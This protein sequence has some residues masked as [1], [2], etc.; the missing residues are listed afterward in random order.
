MKKIILL[1]VLFF[2]GEFIFAQANFTTFSSGNWN[3]PAVWNI[4]SGT[5]ADN[6]PDAD[7]NV[8][9]LDGNTI[10]VTDNQA[11]NS[12]TLQGLTAT[13]LNVNGATLNIYGTLSGPSS[14]FTNDILRTNASGLI[15][16][17]GGS[18]S[19]FGLW[20]YGS[21]TAAWLWRME[22]ALD[23]GATGTGGALRA[24]FL[25][26]SSGI[27]SVSEMRCDSTFTDGTGTIIIDKGATVRFSSAIGTRFPFFN[28]PSWCRSITVNGV[29]QSTSQ[30]Y[31]GGL[32]VYVSG[33]ILNTSF[34]PII[35][36][37]NGTGYPEFS[38]ANKS[39]IEYS[40]PGASELL[41][42]D[43]INRSSLPNPVVDTVVINVGSSFNLTAVVKIT[44]DTCYANNVRFG[45]Y[46]KWLISTNGRI[47]L[48]ANPDI[49]G[50]DK[51][52][53]IVTS[54]GDV[55]V[56]SVGNAEVDLPIGPSITEYNP[57]T[58]KNAGTPDDF[59]FKALSSRPPCLGGFP[60]TSMNYQWDISEA[61]SGGSDV[62]LSLGYS[63]VTKRGSGYLPNKAKIVHCAGNNANYSSGTGESGSDVYIVKGSGFN[64]FSLYGITS[65]QT[66]LPLTFIQSF[67]SHI[68]NTDV[69]LD[70][71]VNCTSSSVTMEMENSVGNTNDFKPI[72]KIVA[73]AGRCKLPFEY[74]DPKAAL[75]DN[76][77][78]IKITDIDG[79]VSYSGVLHVVSTVKGI[80]ISLA[81]NP[82][83]GPQAKFSVVSD[84]QTK[85]SMAITDAQGKVV[86]QSDYDINLGATLINIDV[87]RMQKGIYFVRSIE[88]GKVIG[89]FKLIRQ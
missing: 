4:T 66:V 71:T 55:K 9:I 20:S 59:S 58:I 52:K 3:N 23:D 72:Y 56:K 76:Y 73:D 17:V 27:F 8:T 75:N 39:S 86:K 29:L 13:A 84:R 78:R 53:Y 63:D 82:V 46:G 7:D 48:S 38:Y 37:P 60:L 1:A 83:T 11:V 74:V 42:G 70:W 19:L 18:R 61:Q 10:T 36:Y 22:V 21:T 41:M 33:K 40:N 49:S 25:H 65:D 28:G 62:T 35:S 31:I 87:S 43:E 14:N 81:P 16:F 26:F 44:N 34:N 12:L 2:M 24:S 51:T 6:I 50:Q 15:K 32:N 88:S 85:I 77:Y 47:I 45:A 54:L 79:S 67:T 69:V 57:V 80:A 68:Q 5:D 89:S 30:G 64:Q